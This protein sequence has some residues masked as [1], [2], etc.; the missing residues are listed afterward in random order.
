[1]GISLSQRP[2]DQQKRQLAV[3]FHCKWYCAMSG[4]NVLPRRFS[5]VSNRYI[6]SERVNLKVYQY[7]VMINDFFEETNEQQIFSKY[8]KSILQLIMF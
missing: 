2:V 4:V 6:V 3:R 1:M 8:F 7:Q 5:W